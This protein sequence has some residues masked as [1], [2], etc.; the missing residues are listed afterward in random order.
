MLPILL[1]TLIPGD[2]ASAAYEPWERIC[3]FCGERATADAV[4]NTL[5][6]LPLG[7][8]MGEKKGV[9]RALLWG[10]LLSAGLEA[11]Q[12]F[13]SGRFTSVG[14]M[15]ANSAGAGLGA[16]A[17]RD[18]RRAARVASALCIFG[19]LAPGFL[20]EPDPPEGIYYGQWT[21]VF[22]NMEAYGGRVLEARV[23]EVDVPSWRTPHSAELREALRT[24]AP[25][26]VLV[27]AGP[28]PAGE[29]PIFSMADEKPRF[30]FWLGA[31]GEDVF[32]RVWRRG[33]MLRFQT[34]TWWWDGALSGVQEGDSVH[35]AY[36]LGPEGPCL[37]VQGRMRCQTAMGSVGSWSLLA[38]GGQ[39]GPLFLWGGL[40]WAFLLGIPF[41]LMG[42]SPRVTV[43]LVLG[44]ATA[45]LILS[46]R[47]PY[48]PT[49]WMGLPLLLLGTFLTLMVTKRMDA[50]R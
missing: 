8:V 17:S 12:L 39:G 19:M 42:T 43:S 35:I 44:A 33:T 3:A 27:E 13:L 5:L 31:E 10:A 38:P 18:L 26:R 23:G 30:L 32:V 45:V 40:I 36:E 16:L 29:A 7:W 4:L 50:K 6:F 24:G 34:P 49:P 22:G 20:L 25:I 1:I 41:G 14:D 21:A 46:S 28:P 15:A 11:G 48:W 47:F 37:T 9:L 2:A